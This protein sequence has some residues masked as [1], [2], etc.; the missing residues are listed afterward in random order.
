MQKFT[1]KSEAGLVT[2]DELAHAVGDIIELDE[3][4]QVTIDQVAAGLLEAVVEAPAPE[5]APVDAAPAADTTAAPVETA[6]V[7]AGHFT[8]SVTWADSATDADKEAAVA[9]I[10]DFTTHMADA[11]ESSIPLTIKALTI[12]RD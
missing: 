12:T 11:E 7:P 8:L 4:A 5:P 9:F 6:P 2:P 3:T 10:N 1:V